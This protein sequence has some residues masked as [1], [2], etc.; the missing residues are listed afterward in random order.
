MPCL[1]GKGSERSFIDPERSQPVPGKCHRYPSSIHRSA[2]R[3]GL[4]RP[5]LVDDAGEPGATLCR[6]PKGEKPVASRHRPWTR[7]QKV[8]NVIEFEHVRFHNSYC[9]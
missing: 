1:F 5:H 7:Q 8:L 2:S 6:L 4:A 9:I 3:Y